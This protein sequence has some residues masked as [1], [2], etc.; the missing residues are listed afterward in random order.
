MIHFKKNTGVKPAS[1]EH[2]ALVEQEVELTFTQE[3]LDFMAQNNGGEPIE[4]FFTLGDNEKVVERFLSFVDDYK[5]N[6]LGWYDVAI[7]FNQ[8]F[9]RLNEYLCP[10]SACFGGDFLCFDF[11]NTDEPRIVLW[12]HEESDEDKPYIV[13]V[14]ENFKAFLSMLRA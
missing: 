13:Y 11:E 7:V 5:E 9:D 3:Y 8:I 2:I 1:K 6:P 14:A 10:F 12:L 4:K